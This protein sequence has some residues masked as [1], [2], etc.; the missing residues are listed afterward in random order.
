MCMLQAESPLAKWFS[1][2]S[3]Y[4][5][6]DLTTPLLKMPKLTPSGRMSKT[7]IGGFD[8]NYIAAT[9]VV[10][11]VDILV[12]EMCVAEGRPVFSSRLKHQVYY[13]DAFIP[14]GATHDS[15]VV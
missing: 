11:G 2:N 14:T 8:M 12:L 3:L 1:A 6:I 10:L 5:H 13:H 9:A 4:N 15:G 7:D